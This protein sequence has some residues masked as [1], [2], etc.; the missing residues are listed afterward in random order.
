[1]LCFTE[2]SVRRHVMVNLRKKYAT[3]EEAEDAL[4]L[5]VEAYLDSTPSRVPA[6]VGTSDEGLN[7]S[8]S[9]TGKLNCLTKAQLMDLVIESLALLGPSAQVIS[10]LLKQHFEKHIN[11]DV[12]S[13]I[14]N[15]YAWLA[16]K[17]GIG[18]TVLGFVRLSLE[19][20]RRLEQNNKVNLV[21]KF[22]QGLAMDRP[23]KSGPL[24]P[25]H[26]MPFGLLQYYI[27]FFTCTNVMQV[28]LFSKHLKISN[29]NRTKWSSTRSVFIRDSKIG[30][31]C[32]RNPICS[33]RV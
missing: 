19:A 26:R 27:E 25:L 13:I 21:V 28:I 9:L 16:T 23:D 18:S 14:E 8:P 15:L 29:G 22:C 11:H 20:M 24:I 33:S 31:L 10:D 12:L 5:T 30:Q 3:I 2:A 4:G 7:L 1:M 32:S 17:M 6:S